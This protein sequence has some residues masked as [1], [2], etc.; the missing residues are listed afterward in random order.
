MKGTN[1]VIEFLR[2]DNSF[3]NSDITEQLLNNN[4]NNNN[5]NNKPFYVYGSVH[6]IIFYE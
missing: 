4:N 1:R 3:V 5:N 6:H 2:Q